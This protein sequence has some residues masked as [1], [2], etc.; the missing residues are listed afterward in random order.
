MLFEILSLIILLIISGY[1]SSTEMAYLSSNKLKLELKSNKKG[2]ISNTIKFFL[3]QPQKFFSTILLG[4]NLVNIAFASVSAVIF[5]LMFGLNEI[6]ILI[7]TTALLL[8][9]GEIIPKYLATEFAD[10]IVSSFMVVLKLVYLILSP[11]VLLLTRITDRILDLRKSQQ[12]NLNLLYDKEDIKN[13]LEESHSAGKVFK[14]EK[15][16]I[17]RALELSEQKIYE[18]MRPR[19]E[20]IGISIDSSIIELKKLFLDSGYSKI[21]VY[22]KDLDNIKG[23]VLLKDLFKNPNEISEILRETRFYPETKRTIEVLDDMIDN[24]ISIGVIVDEFG[25]TAGIVSTEDIIEELFGEIKDE[26]DEEEII[27]RKISK[28]QFLL[29]GKVEIDYFNERFNQNLPEG[30]YKTVGG[31]VEYHLGKIPKTG[32]SGKI[33][34]FNF[35]VIKATNTKIELIKL[36]IDEK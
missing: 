28:S 5:K 6:E 36:I 31:L 30:D 19:T 25:G 12:E 13:L 4:N 1:F 11:F 21:I 22:E 14:Q 24:K 32:E 3:Q 33:N 18:C 9:I 8:L 34:G 26:Y 17:L 16:I 35:I 29:S 27:C 15:N 10:G 7:I 23:F 2:F 20:I